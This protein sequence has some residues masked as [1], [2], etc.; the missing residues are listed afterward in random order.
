[1]G[2]YISCISISSR[3]KIPKSTQVILPTG[4]TSQFRHLV[5]AAELMVDFPNFFLVNAGP[6]TIGRRFQPLPADED[7]QLG[8]I[9]IMFPMRR[10]CSMVTTEDME[11]LFK[12]RSGQ[13]S[14][15][16]LSL[17][18]GQGFPV[19]EFKYKVAIMGKSRK[20]MLEIITEEDI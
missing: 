11:V 14:E 3:I 10:A 20:P 4:E 9:Y 12:V 15:P 8:H 17:D 1:M 7:L 5:K 16:R 18:G 13:S 19:P 2:N 6:L